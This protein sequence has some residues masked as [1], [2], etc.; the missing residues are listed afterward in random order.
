MNE[1]STIILS[2]SE[3]EKLVKTYQKYVVKTTDEYVLVRLKINDLTINI[4]DNTKNKD[5]YKVVFNGPNAKDE[6]SKW[7]TPI[8]KKTKVN[9][10]NVEY[11][12][13]DEQIGTDEVGFGDFFGPLVVVAAYVDNKALDLIY[14]LN[15]KDSKKIKD[16]YIWTIGPYLLKEVKYSANIVHNNKYN[17]LIKKGY[18][19][20]K[21]KAMLHDNVMTLLSKKLKVN[22]PIYVDKFVSEDRYFEY[23]NKDKLK[24]KNITFKEKGESY[25]PSIAL[26]SV[27]ARYL[28][29]LEMDKLN[30]RFNEKIPFGAGKRVDDFALY[31]LNKHGLSAFNSITKHNFR[32]YERLIYI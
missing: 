29:L 5:E 18:N 16:E 10:S 17:E 27:I 1:F 14:H 15:I 24:T 26:A 12:S 11:L 7:G 6:A 25:Y 2:K 8:V 19:L 4:Y 32:N 20:N 31:F 3:Y 22:V 21:I 23:I 28:F 30:K 13:L 9:L